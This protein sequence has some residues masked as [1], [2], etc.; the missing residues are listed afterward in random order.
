MW[1]SFGDIIFKILQTPETISIEEKTKLARIEIFGKKN[2][3]HFTGHE[4][5]KIELS[6][7]LNISFCNPKEEI[8]KLRDLKDKAVPQR[9]IIGDENYGKY[10]IEEMKTEI[11]STLATGEILSAKVNIKLSGGQN[12]TDNAYNRD[13]R[14]TSKYKNN[15]Y[16]LQKYSPTNARFRNRPKHNR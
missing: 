2:R 7:Y 9:L 8:Q 11:L 5:D 1:G 10:V 6:I 15:T 16:N 13:R 4:E 12:D 14:N 3:L